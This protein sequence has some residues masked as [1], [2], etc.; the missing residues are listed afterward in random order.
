MGRPAKRTRADASRLPEEKD[1]LAAVPNHQAAQ[2]EALE[3]T[4][5]ARELGIT[6]A[7]VRSLRLAHGND[8]A[9]IR[10]AAERL[11]GH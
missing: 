3:I 9:K 7:R 10:A 8:W 5:L 1:Q 11:R 2:R 4:L 6:P